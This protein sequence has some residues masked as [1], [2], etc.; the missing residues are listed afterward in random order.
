MFG[1]IVGRI[2][3]MSRP[4]KYMMYIGVISG[5]LLLSAALYLSLQSVRAVKDIYLCCNMAKVA[6]K[7]FA[8]GVVCALAYELFS[9]GA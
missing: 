2:N 3:T 4:A 5:M 7:L 8:E 1:R 9:P 6:A